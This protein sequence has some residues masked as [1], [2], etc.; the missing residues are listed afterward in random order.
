MSNEKAWQCTDLGHAGKQNTHSR[1]KWNRH[2]EPFALFHELHWNSFVKKSTFKVLLSF[3]QN[4]D[5]HS[6]LYF[7]HRHQNGLALCRWQSK[8]CLANTTIS[9]VSVIPRVFVNYK[10]FTKDSIC[11]WLCRLISTQKANLQTIY[12]PLYLQMWR[13]LLEGGQSTLLMKLLVQHKPWWSTI[14]QHADR[15]GVKTH[16]EQLAKA[17]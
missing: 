3:L 9:A 17:H 13:Q 5:C 8:C 2:S 1:W 10:H 4:P 16:T 12:T 11:L 15:K 7:S 6:V 14:M